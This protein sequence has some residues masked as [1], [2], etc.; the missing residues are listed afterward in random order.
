MYYQVFIDRPYLNCASKGVEKE[1]WQE[2]TGGGLLRNVGEWAALN[3]LRK[4]KDW[5]KSDER[6]LGD[7]DFVNIVLRHADE[8][9]ENSYRFKPEGFEL[10]D[11]ENV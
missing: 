2:F 3:A 9:M 10:D 1:Q 11:I 6:I 5:D 8:Q 4:G 7:S